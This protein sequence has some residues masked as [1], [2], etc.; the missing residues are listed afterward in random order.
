MFVSAITAANIA[1]GVWSSAI[2]SLTTLWDC[3][4]HYYA[5]AVAVN[6][7]VVL[8]LRP[9]SLHIRWVTATATVANVMSFGIYDGTTHLGLLSDKQVVCT[10]VGSA[11]G[12]IGFKNM[13]G[14][15]ASVA[16]SAVEF[17]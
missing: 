8:D 1:G 15:G 10:G 12:G 16:W 4:W 14:G 2:R 9:A 17:A 6:P 13:S 7:G 5:I 3:C 11:E